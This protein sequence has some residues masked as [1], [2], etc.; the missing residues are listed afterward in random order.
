MPDFRQTEG[1]LI[2]TS[3]IYFELNL[4]DPAF[5]WGLALNWEN[6][7][8]VD[9]TVHWE[10]FWVK[11]RVLEPFSPQTQGKLSAFV[12]PHPTPSRNIHPLGTTKSPTG[13]YNQ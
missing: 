4:V 5:I 1:P 12:S 10:R 7:I 6:T 2:K 11:K 9:K 3:G 8:E 13:D